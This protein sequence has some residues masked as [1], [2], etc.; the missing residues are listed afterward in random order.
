MAVASAHPAF[1]SAR[2]F[3]IS[4]AVLTSD[5][6]VMPSVSRERE[7]S[8]QLMVG[9]GAPGW[10]FTVFGNSAMSSGCSCTASSSTWMLKVPA[11]SVESSGAL[12]GSDAEPLPTCLGEQQR[13][14]MHPGNIAHVT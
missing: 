14:D 12:T 10:P 4:T 7:Q 13:L 3:V 6:G 2:L 9:T 1:R 5:V 11:V 8:N